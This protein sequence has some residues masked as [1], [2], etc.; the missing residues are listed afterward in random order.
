MQRNTSRLFAGLAN[1]LVA[2][3][4]AIG[5]R[6]MFGALTGNRRPRPATIATPG[7][8]STT[9]GV[10]SM[11][12]TVAPVHQ[13]QAQAAIYETQTPEPPLEQ[14]ASLGPRALP[15]LRPG[16]SRAKPEH[17]PAPTY[18]PAI[19]ALA[20][21]FILWGIISSYL[22]SVIGLVLLFIALVGWI[23]ELRHG[24]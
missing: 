1:V 15:P 18:S 16:W 22:I 5:I 14:G 20:I 19:L 4:G 12:D 24:H 2:I 8:S 3:G 17:I 9:P 11:P 6:A 7:N 13:T 21:V 10:Y 23:G